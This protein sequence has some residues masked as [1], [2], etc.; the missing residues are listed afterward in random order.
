MGNWDMQVG[1]MV[2]R[3]GK[4]GHPYIRADPEDYI[5]PNNVRAST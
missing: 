1:H 2:S 4:V 5:L 3:K